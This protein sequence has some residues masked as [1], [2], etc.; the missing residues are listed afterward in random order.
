LPP[1]P[2]SCNKDVVAAFLDRLEVCQQTTHNNTPLYEIRNQR[3]YLFTAFKDLVSSEW[4][5]LEALDRVIV[6]RAQKVRETA[7][8]IDSFIKDVNE[9]LGETTEVGSAQEQQ[10][11]IVQLKQ[12]GVN[13]EENAPNLDTQEIVLPQTTLES[14]R[15]NRTRKRRRNVDTNKVIPILDIYEEARQSGVPASRVQENYFEVSVSESPQTYGS[16]KFLQHL[17]SGL[18]SSHVIRRQRFGNMQEVAQR[19]PWVVVA[20]SSVWSGYTKPYKRIHSFTEEPPMEEPTRNKLPRTGERAPDNTTSSS[21]QTSRQIDVVRHHRSQNQNQGLETPDGAYFSRLDATRE[22]EAAWST[23]RDITGV[24]AVEQASSSTPIKRHSELGF[25]LTAN[26]NMSMIFG[27]RLTSTP[28]GDPPMP[29]EFPLGSIGDSGTIMMSV[30]NEETA[31]VGAVAAAASSAS[32]SE[33][34]SGRL[35]GGC[36][37]ASTPLYS[38][39][40]LLPVINEEQHLNQPQQHQQLA[41]VI[42]RMLEMTISSPPN[43]EDLAEPSAIPP[44]PQGRDWG[45]IFRPRDQIISYAEGSATTPRRPVRRRRRRPRI[46]ASGTN[47]VEP[48][49][50]RIQGEEQEGRSSREITSFMA[51]LLQKAS[52]AVSPSQHKAKALA[53]AALASPNPTKSA[54]NPEV[55]QMKLQELEKN[56]AP[57]AEPLKSQNLTTDESTFQQPRCALKDPTMENYTMEVLQSF[58]AQ[59]ILETV[60]DPPRISDIS[61]ENIVN[62][63]ITP[64][65][66]NISEINLEQPPFPTIEPMEI[67]NLTANLSEHALV[68]NVEI[69]SGPTAVSLCHLPNDISTN[70]SKEVV[71]QSQFGTRRVEVPEIST[72]ISKGVVEQSQFA[73]R[74]VEELEK[75]QADSVLYHRESIEAMG[76]IVHHVDMLRLNIDRQKELSLTKES[77]ESSSNFSMPAVKV[78]DPKIVTNLPQPKIRRVHKMLDALV[79]QPR[80]DM[81]SADFIQNRMD[82][83]ATFRLLLDLKAA[84]IINLSKDGRIFSLK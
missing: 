52:V 83:A 4:V 19:M 50:E 1:I 5:R 2:S 28:A 3:D 32:A 55:D 58:P 61:N 7:A 29:P 63:D 43:E 54:N 69:L 80:V 36:T 35:G 25:S 73:T 57:A 10:N 13:W 65:I 8:T 81:R 30:D 22:E 9:F 62:M 21:I 70:I 48:P 77:P 14:S 23:T 27:R 15:S 34:R 16:S 78:Y 39:R 71:E 6:R 18:L 72:N 45:L 82:A 40:P 20:V 47:Y 84:N 59:K 12:M 74:K 64:D 75:N 17:N 37:P 26:M 33:V 11:A 66:L 56:H 24:T 79:K 60:P 46:P 53:S 31:I 44:P 67:D 41:T 68:T 51:N 76:Y 42:P 49:Q 38:F